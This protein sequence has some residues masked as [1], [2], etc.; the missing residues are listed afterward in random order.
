MVKGRQ[1]HKVQLCQTYIERYILIFLTEL[2]YVGLNSLAQHRHSWHGLTVSRCL[3]G[4]LLTNCT[5]NYSDYKRGLPMM[6][7][8]PKVDT[9]MHITVPDTLKIPVRAPGEPQKKK[10]ILL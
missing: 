7:Q 10:L 9:H 5:S 1:E 2:V 8:G 3:S 4:A 6:V